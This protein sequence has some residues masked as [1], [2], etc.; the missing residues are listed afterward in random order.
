[1]DTPRITDEQARKVAMQPTWHRVPGITA[2]FGNEQELIM[3][4]ALDLLDARATIR[5]YERAL[6]VKK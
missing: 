6:E 2:A 3:A 5:G 1:M 4:L